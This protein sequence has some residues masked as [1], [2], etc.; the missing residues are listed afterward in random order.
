MASILG[1]ESRSKQRRD[2]AERV[3]EAHLRRFLCGRQVDPSAH[4]AQL[5]LL[6]R[7]Q[8]RP[9]DGPGSR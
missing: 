4:S 7:T 8:S 1:C 2:I 3:Y 9:A 5:E 6:G